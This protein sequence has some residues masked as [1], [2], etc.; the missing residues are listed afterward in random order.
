MTTLLDPPPPAPPPPDAHSQGAARDSRAALPPRLLQPLH[1]VAG[2]ARLLAVFRAFFKLVTLVAIVWLVTVLVLGT[3]VQV[4]AAVALPLVGLSWLVV[5]Y[6]AVRFFRP[7]LR[8]HNL[9]S[10]ARM[11]DVALPDTQERLSSAI[12][13]AQEK[14]ARFR[15]SPEL[16]DC[17]IL[18]AEHHAE[19]MNPAAV[20]SGKDVF[21][22][23]LGAIALGMIWF[24]L[25][26]LMTPNVLL[27]LKRTF[28][29]LS[30]AAAPA[31]VLEVMPGNANL[32][33]GQNLEIK[34]QVHPPGGLSLDSETQEIP[35]A[36]L[37]QHFTA[38]SS[39]AAIPD[40]LTDLDRTG[41]RSFR[42]L[43]DHVEQPFTYR[44]VTEGTSTISAASSE[45]YTVAVQSRPGVSSLQITYSYPAYTHLPPRIDPGREGAIEAI[46]GTRIHLVLQSTQALK[47]AKLTI[48]TPA[49]I[50]AEGISPAALYLTP[51][52]A[53]ETTFTADFPVLKSTQYRIQLLNAEGRDNP[54]AQARTIT[55]RPDAL[56]TIA[57]S[58][59]A[60]TLT[61]R[62]DDTVPVRF[63]A[64]DDFGISRIEAIVQI[65]D[66]LPLHVPIQAPP[67]GWGTPAEPRVQG[68][69]DLVLPEVR[70]LSP[71]PA[72]REPRRISYQLEVTDNREAS[73]GGGQTALSA[74]QYLTLDR[75]AIP[76]AQRLD[77]QAAKDLSDAIRKASDRLKDA[78]SKLAELQ[79]NDTA[80]G[81]TEKEKQRLADLTRE[82]SAA[83]Q[84]LARAADAAGDTRMADL[85]RQAREVAQTPLQRAEEHANK[86]QLASDQQ[87]ERKQSEAASQRNVQEARAQLDRLTNALKDT[88]RNQPLAQSLERLAEQQRRLADAL[89]ANPNDPKLLEQQRQLQ[90]KLDD[91]IKQNP[92]LQ[93]PVA[94]ANQSRVNDLARKLDQI[95]QAQQPLA[96]PLGDRVTSAVP[97]QL[98]DLSKKQQELNRDL[99]QFGQQ[100]AESIR[101][102]GARPLDTSKLDP[103]V[104][105]ID[106]NNL[107]QASQDQK[108]NASQLEQ[109]SN[110]LEGAQKR[111]DD[112]AAVR[113]K[114]AAQAAG[115]VRDAQQLQ[116]QVEQLGQQIQDAAANHAPAN[117]PS[118]GA[119]QEASKVADQIRRE[120]Q[121][122]APNTAARAAAQSA[123]EKAN[124]AKRL[125]AQ[126]NAAGAQKQLADAAGQL[127]QAANAA[128]RAGGPAD[129]PPNGPGKAADQARDLAQRQRALAEQAS[130]LDKAQSDAAAARADPTS[131]AASQD[132]LAE[133]ISEAARD[134]RTL[135]QQ[136]QGSAPDLSQRA[137][138]AAQN[139]ERSAQAQK[140]AAQAT[141]SLS[142]QGAAMKQSQSADALDTAQE[143]LTGQRRA[144]A[145][146]PEGPK[147]PDGAPRDGAPRQPD[148]TAAG[149]PPPSGSPEKAQAQGE[150]PNAPGEEQGRPAGQPEGTAQNP[151]QEQGAPQA[152]GQKPDGSTPGKSGDAGDSSAKSPGS[153]SGPG[154][155][156]GQSPPTASG[157]G[158]GKT[159]EPGAPSPSASG[160]PSQSGS[161]AAS[162]SP[163]ASGTPSSSGTPSASG[164]S[165]PGGEADSTS[166]AQA[167]QAARS[168]QSQASGGGASTPAAARQ[169][170]DRLSQAARRLMP[171]NS[172]DANPQG[173]PPSMPSPSAANSPGA[174]PGGASPSGGAG[175]PGDSP[176]GSPGGSGQAGTPSANGGGGDGPR[177]LPPAATGELPKEIQSVGLSPSEWAKLPPKMQEELLH[178]AQQPGP[179]AYRDMIRNYYSR[180]ARMQS[181]GGGD[182]Q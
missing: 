175:A 43:L 54:D 135:Q 5:L 126:G 56:P 114:N 159:G 31:P 35:R 130:R 45:S 165:A 102:T 138:K 139:L 154:S 9:A 109:L 133:R 21:R 17:L 58:A 10:A 134:A 149:S 145:K 166:A 141:R 62:P 29:P 136:T 125:A 153:S 172:A 14:D 77:N 85:A 146:A 179:P 100:Q 156:V 66:N 164:G 140:D 161:P 57:I 142:A 36:T 88:A 90:Q 171:G 104:R 167:V 107:D 182:T 178:S 98:K 23:F 28:N 47:S 12:E 93:K 59:P 94:D 111:L 112:S 97:E 147:S 80:R 72:G 15:G 75:A 3:R 71:S 55:A 4:P 106:A 103:I 16:V 176:G 163:S 60:A 158:Q 144:T 151:S 157:Q 131:A 49:A 177:S 11:V 170:A 82:I 42:A 143:A 63:A 73:L 101:Q 113:E 91:L 150:A 1:V 26:V 86:A 124:A 105:K 81:L 162:G 119:N 110:R 51:D 84:D 137:E 127:S 116:K 115:N 99:S 41:R 2:R 32:A 83:R 95:E 70:K 121:Q 152:Q 173:A 160:A 174:T 39:G 65:D 92:Q 37:I 181:E 40:R 148:R 169:A 68:D 13:I 19:C 180:I 50:G 87:A 48:D 129:A 25:L 155:R 69:W 123:M 46:V 108:A 79:K 44:L 76:L 89:A 24:L 38:T 117:R 118:D 67:G 61:V 33:Q 30:A 52:K 168:A 34:L 20:V 22:W 27:G 78:D 122:L 132:A 6:G 8:R 53:A 128:Q 7:V 18:Q 120:A 96:D 74:R 64:G